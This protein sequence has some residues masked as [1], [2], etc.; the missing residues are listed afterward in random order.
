MPAHR[1]HTLHEP[2]SVATQRFHPRKSGLDIQ[3]SLIIDM[4]ENSSI[5][6]DRYSGRPSVNKSMAFPFAE[7]S[8]GNSSGRPSSDSTVIEQ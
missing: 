4:V 1:M 2:Q 8:G 5:H 3:F 6:R 7:A